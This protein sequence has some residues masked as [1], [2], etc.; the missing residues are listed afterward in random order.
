MCFHGG[1]K[2]PNHSMTVVVQN[3][4]GMSSWTHRTMPA[5][6]REGEGARLTALCG[7]GVAAHKQ[8]QGM[9]VC[10]H[11]WYVHTTCTCCHP[12]RRRLVSK[13]LGRHEVPHTENHLRRSSAGAAPAHAQ[14]L[15]VHS[16][17]SNNGA[18]AAKANPPR[19]NP[20]ISMMPKIVLDPSCDERDSLQLRDKH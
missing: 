3:D 20:T 13:E 4:C 16:W 17:R 18:C 6:V 2:H 14:E 1:C 5:H 15:R 11:M 8:W 10:V 12:E 9:Q 7:E 19:I